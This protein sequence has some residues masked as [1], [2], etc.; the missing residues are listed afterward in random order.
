MRQDISGSE[1]LCAR[2][3]DHPID[4]APLSR[5]LA[6]LV[7]VIHADPTSLDAGND[8]R[9]AFLDGVGGRDKPGHDGR[10]QGSQRQ[11]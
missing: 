7:P 5:V 3:Q 11:A 6:G 9:A 4:A 2:L 8:G 1:R 10:L